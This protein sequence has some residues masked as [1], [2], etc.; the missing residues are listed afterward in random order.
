MLETI[1]L[2]FSKTCYKVTQDI[3]GLEFVLLGI[4]DIWWRL[5]LCWGGAVLYIV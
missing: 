2:D 1:Y 4:T 3:L 5:I